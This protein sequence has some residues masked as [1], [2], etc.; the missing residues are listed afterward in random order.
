MGIIYNI[1]NNNFYNEFT[2]KFNMKKIKFNTFVLA[3]FLAV[4]F[5]A[6]A[7]PTPEAVEPQYDDDGNPITELPSSYYS[8]Q[9]GHG[10]AVASAAAGITHGHAKGAHIYSMKTNL[11]EVT[12]GFPSIVNMELL[13]V[14][15]DNKGND[16]PTIVNMSFGRSHP[17]FIPDWGSYRGT[18]WERFETI[19]DPEDPEVATAINFNNRLIDAE[20][21]AYDYGIKGKSTGYLTTDA[22]NPS[23]P[24]Y[25][26]AEFVLN[27]QSAELDTAV[28]Q[29]IQSGIHVVI[30]S[31][32]AVTLDKVLLFALI[33][34]IM[35]LSHRV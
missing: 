24:T 28:D 34:A 18:E 35:L 5:S 4:S 25:E 9:N 29:L 1:N 7:I 27:I 10:T 26:D 30:A 13:K 3:M 12:D 2:R 21:L 14:W 32:N 22:A 17:T 33:I 23:D 8:D 19:R 15:H 11:S 16:R 20:Y 31:G 6:K